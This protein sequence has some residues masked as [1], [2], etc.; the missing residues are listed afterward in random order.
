MAQEKNE[1][2]WWLGCIAI[3]IVLVGLYALVRFVKWA[4]SR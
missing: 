3:P 1:D 4:W 2:P